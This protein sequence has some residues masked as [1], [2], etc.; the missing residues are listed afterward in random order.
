MFNG[1]AH[2]KHQQESNQPSYKHRLP[3]TYT[4]HQFSAL[5]WHSSTFRACFIRPIYVRNFKYCYIANFK[6]IINH[7]YVYKN[8]RTDD[9]IDMP[10]YQKDKIECVDFGSLT[11]KLDGIEIN[12]KML[13]LLKLL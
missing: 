4:T 2:E 11:S 8:I 9:T 12:E 10:D 3:S 6:L 7:R 5:F 13:N 1:R